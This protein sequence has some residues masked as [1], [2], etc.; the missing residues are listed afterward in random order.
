MGDALRIRQ[1]LSNLLSNAVKFTDVGGIEVT[2]TALD[3]ADG[4]TQSV[5]VAVVDTG[6][7]LSPEQQKR[8]FDEFAQADP[9]TTQRYG[10]TGLGLVICRRLASLMGGD[11]TMDSEVGAGTTMRLV[12]SLPVG[13]P[14]QVVPEAGF[15]SRRF[16]ASRPTPT[17]DEAR[18]ERSLV[19]IAE[20]HSVNRAVLRQQLSAIGFCADIAVDG[21]E[22]FD[23]FTTGDYAMVLTDVHMPRLDGYELAQAIRRHE[24][25]HG[26]P[27]TPVMAL[28][29]NVMQGEPQ[30]CRDAGMDDFAAKPA[31]I[32]LLAAKLREWMPHVEFATAPVEEPAIDRR[33]N[34]GADGDALDRSVLAELTGGDTDLGA[35]VLRD[36]V[37]SAAEDMHELDAAIAT[38]D[39]A[40]VRRHAH[41]IKGAGAVVGARRATALA[42]RIETLERDGNPDILGLRDELAVALDL[43]AEHLSRVDPDLPA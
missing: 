26:W 7:G 25:D 33:A 41:R 6:I 37:A 9:T 11:V 34:A 22:A 24:A 23:R 40:A 30:R 27:R 16:Q 13:D 17:R 35:A 5:E 12:V 10:G 19:L 32:P 20:D 1:I 18:R 29:A 3:D 8:L 15:T 42:A 21:Q 31:T 39:L 14:A 28:T 38:G 2:A 36:F 43:V 4:K